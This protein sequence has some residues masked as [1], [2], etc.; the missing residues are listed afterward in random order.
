MYC[1]MQV[2]ASSVWLFILLDLLTTF[3]SSLSLVGAR[4]RDRSSESRLSSFA[5]QLPG[6]SEASARDVAARYGF[7]FISKVCS[8]MDWN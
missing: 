1:R 8:A 6:L 3:S 2:L 7:R 4:S 5:V